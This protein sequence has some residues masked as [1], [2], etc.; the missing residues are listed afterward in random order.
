[1]HTTWFQV[2]IA[3]GTIQSP[4]ILQLAGIGP[5]EELQRLNITVR[6]DLPVGR[7][8]QNQPTYH[9]LAFSAN[10]TQRPVPLLNDVQNYLNNDRGPL[11]NAE[12]VEN[13]GF[14]SSSRWNRTGVPD[15]ELIQV[16]MPN[17][18]LGNYEYLR[19]VYHFTDETFQAVYG[20]RNVSKGAASQLQNKLDVLECKETFL[21]NIRHSSPPK[22]GRNRDAAL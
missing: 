4:Q 3:A 1:M 11:P 15:L 21:R 16:S 13:L 19:R 10:Y 7:N 5:R 14:Y 18:N 17:G 2:I 8:F 22:I 9:A 20:G 6:A 12:N